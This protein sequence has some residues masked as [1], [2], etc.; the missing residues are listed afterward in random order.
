MSASLPGVMLNLSAPGWLV[1]MYL[2]K[3]LS[4]PEN[5]YWSSFVM[6]RIRTPGLTDV[7]SVCEYI[8]ILHGSSDT[9]M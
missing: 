8:Y 6:F 5:L 3:G 4:E 2:E 7:V 1:A 9:V